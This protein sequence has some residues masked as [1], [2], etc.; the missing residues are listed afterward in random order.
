MPG[1]EAAADAPCV[2]LSF[3]KNNPKEDETGNQPIFLLFSRKSTDKIFG[4]NNE[5]KA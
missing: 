1:A 3:I 2:A 5:K 4:K